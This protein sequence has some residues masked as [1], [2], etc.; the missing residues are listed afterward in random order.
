MN[1]DFLP[2][3]LPKHL[4]SNGAAKLR[5]QIL[6]VLLSNLRQAQKHEQIINMVGEYLQAHGQLYH[7]ADRKDFDSAMFYDA[8]RGVLLR[9]RSDE[10]QAWLSD[11][12]SINRADHLFKRIIA[13]VETEAISSLYA[14][15][16]VPAAY[17]A[18]RDK[19]IYIS[20]GNGKM[21]R[22][23]ARGVEMVPNG[24]DGVLF[25][26]GKTL[27]EW[28]L[29]PPADPFETCAVFRDLSCVA[30]HAKLLLQLFL[31]MIP[32]DLRLKALLALIGGVGSGKTRIAKAI[33][34][35]L[36][37]P[38]L[39]RSELWCGRVSGMSAV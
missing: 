23:T 7:H 38:F 33:A 24:K 36:G 32:T 31:L 16:I 8:D 25:Q 12:T 18:N 34:E 13:H 19:K 14:R 29:A 30:G 27:T 17:W 2:P 11:L 21:A 3:R 35:L 9:L 15:G 4:G 1:T 37:I 28:E 5:D 10:F 39:Y 22:I 26:A 6:Q 20:N